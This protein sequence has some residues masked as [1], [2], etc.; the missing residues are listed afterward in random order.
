MTIDEAIAIARGIRTYEGIGELLGSWQS[1]SG[2]WRLEFERP[3]G[4]PDW[5]LFV[6][7][8]PDG[9]IVDMIVLP[10]SKA[11]LRRGS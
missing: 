10:N 2:I 8:T 5:S 7:I 3:H 4:I 1:N 11:I 9:A 6:T